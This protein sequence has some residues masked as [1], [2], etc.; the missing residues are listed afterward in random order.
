MN[1]SSA[2]FTSTPKVETAKPNRTAETLLQEQLKAALAITQRAVTLVACGHRC[3]RRSCRRFSARMTDL[4]MH[5]AALVPLQSGAFVFIHEGKS[6]G[7]VQLAWRIQP[8]G[9]RDVAQRKHID[10]VGAEEVASTAGV[11]TA[12][13]EVHRDL[14]ADSGDCCGLSS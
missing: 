11:F 12:V 8:I 6:P 10:Q 1:R 4:G 13:L 3:N 2:R 14:N 9:V 7:S 5:Y